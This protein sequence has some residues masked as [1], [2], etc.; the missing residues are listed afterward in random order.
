MKTLSEAPTLHPTARVHNSHLGA[1]SELAEGVQFFDSSLG[2]F[3]Y[4]MQY[5]QA[6][7]AEIG[8]FCSIASFVRLNPGNHP[9]QRPSSHH[10]TYRAAAYGLGQDDL[11]FFQWRRDHPVRVGH[12]VW[13]GHNA[14]V[15][16]GVTIGNG[17]VVGT[18]AVV[19]RDVAPYTVVVGVPA[20]PLRLRFDKTIIE[21]LEDTAWWDW[22][23][24]LLRERLGDF[25]G[26]VEEFL[27]KYGR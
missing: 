10:F 27:E 15:M 1:W 19:T 8:R 11:E 6:I 20:R 24:Q 14:S 18:G 13:I 9:I 21:R 4:L 23:H 12:D 7:Y 2:D 17:A 5:S 22:P 3:S 26:S 25:R 16:P